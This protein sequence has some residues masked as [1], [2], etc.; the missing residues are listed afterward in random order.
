MSTLKKISISYKMSVYSSRLARKPH[1]HL[2]DSFTHL[3]VI[4]STT[5][6]SSRSILRDSI[7]NIL[8][9]SYIIFLLNNWTKKLQTIGFIVFW[10]KTRPM[11]SLSTSYVSSK[12]QARLNIPEFLFESE[13]KTENLLILN[14]LEVYWKCIFI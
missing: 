9:T 1:T 7:Y 13:Y 4:P 10:F 3:Q 14:N 5:A 6:L 12:Y 2:K 11:V 8:L